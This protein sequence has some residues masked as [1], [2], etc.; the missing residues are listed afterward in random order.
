MVTRATPVV[1]L[2]L[3]TLVISQPGCIDR[4]A[5][6]HVRRL[7]GVTVKGIDGHGFNMLV[8]C[9][10]ENPNPLGAKVSEI[11]FS[12]YLGQSL[13]GRGRIDGP[14]DVAARS[15]FPLE[16]PVRVAYENLPADLPARVADGTVQLRTVTDLSAR[17]RLGTYRMH[18]VSR[19]RTE[20]A[21]A[22]E[23]AI[24]GPFRGRAVQILGIRLGGMHLRRIQL[25]ARVRAR[26]LFAFP[27]RIR[28]GSYRIAI[29][30]EHFGE[31][32]LSRPITIQ[33][34]STVETEMAV[35][36]THGAVG[37]TILAMLGQEP[38]F[39]LTGTLWIDP[40]GGVSRLP[41]EVEA[42]ASIFGQ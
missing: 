13:V 35:T 10:L 40:I 21:K 1:G 7:V 19:G 5:D 16:V 18:L 36:A 3:I 2:T 34:R 6:F 41:L 39:K 26:N 17:T 4:L 32:T 38:R 37:K 9:E 30:G 27:L 12:S 24:Q 20:I 23:V 14:I 11:R 31:G 15:R 33:A 22:L 8:H 42:D 29:N 28:R 25:L